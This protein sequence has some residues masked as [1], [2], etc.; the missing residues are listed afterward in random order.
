MIENMAYVVSANVAGHQGASF[1]TQTADG[2]SKIIDY[3]GRVLAEAGQGERL[4]GE[5]LKP[6]AAGSGEL[7]RAHRR[8][9]LTVVTIMMF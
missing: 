9:S 8:C 5:L 4:P 6:S 7:A 3:Y 1:L 2:L